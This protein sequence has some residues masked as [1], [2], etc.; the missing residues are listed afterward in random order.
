MHLLHTTIAFKKELRECEI[1]SLY[2]ARW[3][4]ENRIRSHK[5]KHVNIKCIY[6]REYGL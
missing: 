2:S 5:Q 6:L 4:C 3:Y 1:E